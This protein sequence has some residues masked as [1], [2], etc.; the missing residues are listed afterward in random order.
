MA[1][2]VGTEEGG[3]SDEKCVIRHEHTLDFKS[4]DR[5]IVERAHPDKGAEGEI[6]LTIPGY[7]TMGP[8]YVTLTLDEAEKLKELIHDMIRADVE[9]IT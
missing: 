2:D 8:L 1:A 9:V 5:L 6:R 7:Y 4:K 3:M